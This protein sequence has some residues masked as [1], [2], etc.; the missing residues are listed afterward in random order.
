MSNTTEQPTVDPARAK[1]EAKARAKADKAYKKASRPWFKKKRYLLP[2]AVLVIVVAFQLTNGGGDSS[3]P[4][5]AEAAG[6]SDTAGSG[7]SANGDEKEA[8]EST[9]N[10]FDETYGTFKPIKKSGQGDSTLKLPDGASA[11]V[12]S[13]RHNGSANFAVTTLDANN[14]PTGDLLANTIGA[15]KGTAA[16]GLND[17]GDPVK[18]QITADGHWTV[19]VSPIS[20]A[21]ELPSSADGNGDAVFLYTGEAADWKLEHSG[22]ANFMVTQYG[23][24]MPNLMVNEI[25]RYKGTVPAVDGPSVV[26]VMADGDWSI[27]AK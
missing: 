14:Q 18:L 4:G 1:L 22:S 27:E 25:G 20:S 8:T 6:A 15:Y 21:P 7:T 24:I 17:M 5:A 2:L 3:D 26:T 19:K 9:S 12:V 13:M 10:P 23:D 11:A 16:Y